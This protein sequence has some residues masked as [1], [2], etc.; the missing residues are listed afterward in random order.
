MKTVIVIP[1]YNEEKA[2]G[3][4]LKKLKSHVPTDNVIVIDDGSSDKTPE[5]A[6]AHGVTVYQHDI[7]R[8]L[9]GAL[10]TGLKAGL[11]HGADIIVT[12]DADDQHDPAEITTLTG[13]IES[14]EADVVIGSRLLD[15]KGMPASRRALN[16]GGNV[17]TWGLFGIWVSD[18]QS[19]FR[20]FSARSARAINLKTNK[21]EVSSEIIKEIK[22]NRLSFKEVPIKA[23]YT[24]YSM[25]KGQN[26][27]V[28]I[29]TV[30]RLVLLRF[31]K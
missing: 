18:T 8:G 2:I 9:G 30:F 29:K 25:S 15:A 7:N 17:V 16:W 5:I 11:Q 4:V 1:A 24:E 28:G 6:R 26:F 19:G 12:M 14:K 20:A 23:I 31:R 3:G 22:G 27:G 10:G 13:P 21:M